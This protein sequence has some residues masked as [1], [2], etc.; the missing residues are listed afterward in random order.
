MGWKPFG[1][2]RGLLRCNINAGVHTH[3]RGADLSLRDVIIAQ[4]GNGA[5]ECEW[6]H[7]PEE[8]AEDFGGFWK[9]QWVEFCLG[10]RRLAFA[11]SLKPGQW[12]CGGCQTCWG[13]GI[14]KSHHR[15]IV[16]LSS[17]CRNL[18]LKGNKRFRTWTKKSLRVFRVSGF[19]CS[20]YI[21]VMN[22]LCTFHAYPYLA[23]VHYL[24][25]WKLLFS[26]ISKSLI[27][28]PEEYTHCIFTDG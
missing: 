23:M 11:Y 18:L 28:I 26:L 4:M 6:R 24:R 27:P 14:W 2:V 9:S 22:I 5:R 19:L 12:P 20:R 10:R 25:T 3:T 7:A 1:S 13:A 21:Y 8:S 15:K 17:L 16:H